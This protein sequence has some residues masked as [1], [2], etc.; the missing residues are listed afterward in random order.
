MLILKQIAQQEGISVEA[1][2]LQARIAAKAVEFGT[3]PKDL[4]EELEQEG[5]IE[6]LKDMLLAESTLDYL[7]EKNGQEN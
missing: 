7:I 1:A 2:D 6:R 3:T 5:G 4:R